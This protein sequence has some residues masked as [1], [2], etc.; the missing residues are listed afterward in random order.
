MMTSSGLIIEHAAAKIN[1]ALH[2]TGQRGDGYHLLDSL[3]VFTVFGDSVRCAPSHSDQ[4][5]IDGPL[6][7]DVPID[8]T[9]S[10]VQARAFL[11]DMFTGFD[12]PPVALH[13]TKN[14][15]S[16]AGIGGGSADAAATLR[17]LARH[18]ALPLDLLDDSDL[19][20]KL[21]AD[22]PMCL[23]QEPLIAS[24]I[25]ERLDGVQT[26]LA[27]IHLVLVNC[28]DAVSTPAIF[29]ALTHK[30][31]A[32]LPPMPEV[33]NLQGLIDYLKTT[34]NDL[35]PPALA[36]SVSIHQSLK[37]LETKDALYCQMSGSGATCF[38]IF[39][40]MKQA[41]IAAR[42]I[43]QQHPTWFCVATQSLA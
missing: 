11:R 8:H 5:T 38:G 13:L 29:R 18:W 37:A 6:A 12:C 23:R 2:V 39:Q 24:G 15:P 9:N 16:A 32:P 28:G 4:L 33:Q 36:F 3:V 40:S 34:R 21:G 17:A 7:N 41:D 31:N 25:G 1:L 19:A 20:T 26:P 22:V 43:Q 30:N 35:Q 42:A 14:L 10:M 27:E